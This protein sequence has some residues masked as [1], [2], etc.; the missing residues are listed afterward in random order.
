MSRKGGACV[1]AIVCNLLSVVFFEINLFWGVTLTAHNLSWDCPISQIEC[2]FSSSLI[3]LQ[4]GVFRLIDY[5]IF[6][7]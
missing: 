5:Q 4:D 6:H 1:Y 7:F 3:E 2:A